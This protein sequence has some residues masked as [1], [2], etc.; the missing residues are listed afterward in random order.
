MFN[1]FNVFSSSSSAGKRR[2][3]FTHGGKVRQ[4]MR[5]LVLRNLSAEEAYHGD[6]KIP[7]SEVFSQ[8]P[9][10]RIRKKLLE[11]GNYVR[12]A[13]KIIKKSVR[14]PYN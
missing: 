13:L 11:K 7:D 10:E 2:C 12:C 4:L 1:V 8:Y 3:G 6:A 5:R 14:F 9:D